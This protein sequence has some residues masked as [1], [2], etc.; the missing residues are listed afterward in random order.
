VMVY[1]SFMDL[2]VEAN[3]A[4]GSAAANLWFFTGIGL[5]ALVLRFIPHPEELGGVKEKDLA[6]YEYE[7]SGTNDE[8]E[9]AR[10]RDLRRRKGSVK[11]RHM[12]QRSTQMHRVG[13]A[14]VVGMCLHKIPEG[15]AVYISC[16]KG[17]QLGIPLALGMALHNLP[18]GM[19]V[20]SPI[21]HSTH[22]RFTAFRYALVLGLCEPFGALLVGI[23]L[24]PFLSTAVL[25]ALLAAVAGIMVLL[26]VCQ[27]LPAA[28]ANASEPHVAGAVTAGMLFIFVTTQLAEW[29]M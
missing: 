27:L 4:I 28:F 14:T 15:I 2:L 18:E 5:F 25:G 6:E 10:S 8:L 1:I 24:H 12:L 26:S 20:V 13:I 22:R 17:V 16:L 21:Y 7:K 9:D 11:K 29:L 3:T 19:A 23:L